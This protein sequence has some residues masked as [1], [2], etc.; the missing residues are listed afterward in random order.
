[1]GFNSAFKGLKEKQHASQPGVESPLVEY[2]EQ[3]SPD[4]S[5]QE[6]IYSRYSIAVL[7]NI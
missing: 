3:N 2:T 6:T 7:R 4:L 5:R 1:M